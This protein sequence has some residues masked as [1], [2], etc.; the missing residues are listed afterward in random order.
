MVSRPNWVMAT[1]D[2]IFVSDIDS[3]IDETSAG[4]PV[5][6]GNPI[7]I[8]DEECSHYLTT[9]RARMG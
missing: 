7:F 4:I 2:R 5:E 3:D 1:P 9:P 6:V 8:A